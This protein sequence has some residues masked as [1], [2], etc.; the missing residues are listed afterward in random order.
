LRANFVNFNQLFG[1]QQA[2]A[3]HAAIDQSGSRIGDGRDEI[4]TAK[5]WV[6]EERAASKQSASFD[7][8]AGEGRELAGIKIEL[9]RAFLLGPL[10][11]GRSGSWLRRSG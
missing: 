2:D 4:A 3:D 11:R 9:F 1:R 10:R 8:S 6:A 7:L 5:P